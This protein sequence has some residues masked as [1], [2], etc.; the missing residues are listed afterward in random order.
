MSPPDYAHPTKIPSLGNLPEAPD[1]ETALG[2]DWTGDRPAAQRVL[3]LNFGFFKYGTDD[4]AHAAAILLSI[5]LLAALFIISLTAIFS[6][7]APMFE[8]AINIFGNAFLFVA[9]VAIGQRFTDK[10]KDDD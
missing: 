6:P 1:S 5:G 3:Y 10:T 7:N 4:K 9:G 8:R 2:L